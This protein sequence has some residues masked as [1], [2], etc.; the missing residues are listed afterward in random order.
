MKISERLSDFKAP[1]PQGAAQADQSQ[2]GG[3]LDDS[4]SLESIIKVVSSELI[5]IDVISEI[6]GDF[7]K[8]QEA[9]EQVKVVIGE[10][11]QTFQDLLANIKYLGETDTA[12]AL[13]KLFDI[14]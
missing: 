6:L 12:G 4:D 10:I 14:T 8:K 1:Q 13:V 2:L 11:N 5:K 7:F 9:G 3:D